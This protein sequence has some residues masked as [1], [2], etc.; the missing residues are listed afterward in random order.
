MVLSR[1]LGASSPRISRK[2]QVTNFPVTFC[3]STGS[4]IVITSIHPVAQDQ[5]A[6]VHRG[7]KRAALSYK[8]LRFASAPIGKA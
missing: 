1:S 2:A 6:G 8:I 3:D 7:N 4:E 5:L